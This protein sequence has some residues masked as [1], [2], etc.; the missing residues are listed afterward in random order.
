MRS[1]EG[2]F[3]Q[4][5]FSIAFLVSLI[6]LTWRRSG[7]NG[8]KPSKRCNYRQGFPGACL[9][10]DALSI[11]MMALQQALSSSVNELGERP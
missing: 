11:A 4:D 8:E 3:A 1:L 9:A 5:P 2:L 10:H 7:L 6:S